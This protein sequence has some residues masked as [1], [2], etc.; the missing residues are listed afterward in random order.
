MKSKKSKIIL[1]LIIILFILLIGTIYYLNKVKEKTKF[2]DP[3]TDDVLNLSGFGVFFEKYS[4]DLKSSEIASDLDTLTTE[5]LPN[6]YQ[7]LDKCNNRKIEEY[8]N[9][10]KNRIKKNLGIVSLSDFSNFINKIKELKINLEDWYRLDL[11][12]ETF[13]DQSD[14]SGYAYIEYEVSFK[15]DDKLRFSLYISKKSNKTPKYIINIL[16]KNM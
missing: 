12:K 7:K 16:G 8:Y 2:D 9:D 3:K 14:K 10:N 11:V 15:N 1:L 13:K 6:M 4:G 5:Y